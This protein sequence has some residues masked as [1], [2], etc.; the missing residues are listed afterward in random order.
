MACGDGPILAF[1]GLL[2]GQ[3]TVQQMT[4]LVFW[5]VIEDGVTRAAQ[6]HAEKAGR[7]VRGELKRIERQ[8]LNEGLMP[9]GD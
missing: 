2:R 4:L 3:R 6:R 5:A 1:R 7:R 9:D 8:I